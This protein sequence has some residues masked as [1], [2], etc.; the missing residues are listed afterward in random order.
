[1]SQPSLELH[2]SIILYSPASASLPW[3]GWLDAEDITILMKPFTEA[4]L[5]EVIFHAMEEFRERSKR[6]RC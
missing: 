5:R 3:P 6:R 2:P 4:R 1:M